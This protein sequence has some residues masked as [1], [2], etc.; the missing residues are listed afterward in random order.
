[1]GKRK[2]DANASL[3]FGFIPVRNVSKLGFTPDSAAA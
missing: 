3:F 2:R 1:M